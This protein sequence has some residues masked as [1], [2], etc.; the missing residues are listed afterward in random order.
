MGTQVTRTAGGDVTFAAGK[1]G[2]GGG[3]VGAAQTAAAA[4]AATTTTTTTSK[5]G[6]EKMQKPAWCGEYALGMDAF[7]QGVVRQAATAARASLS[8]RLGPRLLALA[9]SEGALRAA[10]HRRSERAQVGAKSNNL[11]ALR[12]KLP[13]WIN[14]PPSVA[15]PFSTF[16]AVLDAPQN[17][18]VKASL[19]GHYEL[20]KGGDV[21]ALATCRQAIQSLTAPP[22][23][24]V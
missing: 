24:Q 7:K 17:R 22:Q 21:S 9:S 10:H 5:A 13:P 8:R 15:V 1:A 3:G 14:L 18:D 20:V 11:A 2:G 19:M 6:A 4:A 12:G 16:E 23:L